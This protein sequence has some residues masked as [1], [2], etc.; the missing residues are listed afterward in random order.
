MKPP[1]FLIVAAAMNGVIGRENALPWRLKTDM[2]HFRRTTLGHPVLMGRKTWESIGAK[3]LPER[4][5]L[6]LSHQPGFETPGADC[7]SSLEAALAACSPEKPVFVIGGAKVYE[8]AL[9]LADAV[10]LTE[11]QAR[12]EG[13]AFFPP[14]PAAFVETHTEHWPQGPHDS[15]P[16][17]FRHWV[18]VSSS[19]RAGS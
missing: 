8:A 17:V 6:V 5:N 11:V 18:R 9:P 7:F 2:A 4:R 13:D 3:P 19:D 15:H 12:P 16:M 1:V 10:F 14:L